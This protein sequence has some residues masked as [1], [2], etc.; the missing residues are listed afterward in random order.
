M[1]TE[2]L[3]NFVTNAKKDSIVIIVPEEKREKF[4]KESKDLNP[5]LVRTKD[6]FSYYDLGV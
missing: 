1:P 4:L 5:R 3:S 6:G 2:S